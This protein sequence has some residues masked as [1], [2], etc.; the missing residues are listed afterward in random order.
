M[1]GHR[2]EARESERYWGVPV[3]SEERAARISYL[4]DIGMLCLWPEHGRLFVSATPIGDFS[5]RAASTYI[6]AMPAS[7]WHRVADMYTSRGPVS[8][9]RLVELGAA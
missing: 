2:H 3:A 9:D 7:Q 4:D 6:R 1:N 5:V 8:G